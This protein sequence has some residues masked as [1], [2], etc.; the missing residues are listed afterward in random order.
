MGQMLTQHAH[1]R[2][3]NAQRLLMSSALLKVMHLKYVEEAADAAIARDAETR[4]KLTPHPKRAMELLARLQRGHLL[5]LALLALL[6]LAAGLL[7]DFLLQLAEMLQITVRAH[8][9]RP[10]CPPDICANDRAFNYRFG[11]W[12]FLS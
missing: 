7:V 1:V 10:I 6:V 12:C 11:E 3:Y 5:A 8:Y 4:S 2:A 9:A